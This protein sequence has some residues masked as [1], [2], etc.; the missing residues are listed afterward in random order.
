MKLKYAAIITILT[1]VSVFFVFR[2]LNNRKNHE[3][4]ILIQA[5]KEITNEYNVKKVQIESEHAESDSVVLERKL[6]ALNSAYLSKI[7][8]LL[9]EYENPGE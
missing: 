5:A 1:I 4:K 7:S 9:A 6:H 3:N 8:E 2:F